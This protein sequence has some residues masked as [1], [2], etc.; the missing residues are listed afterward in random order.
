MTGQNNWQS[1]PIN[2]KLSMCNPFLFCILNIGPIKWLAIITSGT[3]N[4]NRLYIYPV[5]WYVWFLF[6]VYKMFFMFCRMKTR[7]Y[8]N[9]WL[10]VLENGSIGQNGLKSMFTPVIQCLSMLPY[11]YLMW[12]MCAHHFSLISSLNKQKEYCLLVIINQF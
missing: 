11:W 8:L 3:I 5:L 10:P 6:I 12:T 4:R 7:Q 9:M 1:G 2:K